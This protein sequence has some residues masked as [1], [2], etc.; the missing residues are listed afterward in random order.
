MNTKVASAL[1]VSILVAAVLGS[2]ALALA[3]E[4]AAPAEPQTPQ[5]AYEQLLT[6]KSFAFGGVGFA[7]I[8]SDGERAFHTIAAATNALELFRVALTNGTTEARL[9][10]LCGIRKLAPKRFEAHAK[11]LVAAN[12]T[13]STMS[14]CIV[15]ELPASKVVQNIAAGLYDRYFGDDQASRSKRR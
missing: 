3:A 7:G 15:T 4:S 2:G 10:A 8:T 5:Q 1:A 6:V 11:P 9:Y 12:P 13:A 14:G